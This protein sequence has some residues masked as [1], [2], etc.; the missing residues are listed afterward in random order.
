MK[1][2]IQNIILIMLPFTFSLYSC[3]KVIDIDLKEAAPKLV[4]EG[5]ISSEPGPYEVRLTRS[6]G[7]FD[8]TAV[9]PVENAQVRMSDEEGNVE[10]LTESSPGTYLTESLI[11]I[12]NT[13]YALEV[14]VEDKVITASEFLP[15]KV[16]I[17][18]LSYEVT[19]FGPPPSAPGEINVRLLCTFTDPAET[20]DFYRFITYLNG[21]QLDGLFNPY[22]VTDD[23]L[24]NGRT[25]SVSL[26]FI[27]ILPGDSIKVDLQSIGPNTYE[28]FNSLNDAIDGGGI[29]STPYNPKTNLDNGALGYFG[30]YTL[31]S[32]SIVIQQ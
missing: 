30:S 11:G 25:F 2:Y 20:V 22:Y 16:E 28:Y 14:I 7:Y 26:P 17:D 29:G 6:G 19:N 15:K 18:S 3:E 9:Q 10:L 27:R 13:T 4:I 5:N 23:E 1:K 8:N 31:S 32:D 21:E 24:F 12:E